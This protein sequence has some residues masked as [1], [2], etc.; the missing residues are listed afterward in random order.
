M[1][2]S[3]ILVLVSAQRSPGRTCSGPLHISVSRAARCSARGRMWASSRPCVRLSMCPC[4]W[5]DQRPQESVCSLQ[6]LE[7]RTTV[8]MSGSPHLRTIQRRVT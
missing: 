8:H 2:A 7:C 1:A 5:E 4:P 3:S 6:G